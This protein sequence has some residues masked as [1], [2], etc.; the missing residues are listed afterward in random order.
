MATNNCINANSTTPLPIVD[1]GTQVIAVTTAPTATAFAGWDA[2]K[3]LSANSH[4]PGFLSTASSASP[5]TLVVGSAQLQFITGSTAQTIVMPVANTLVAGMNWTI[6]N[7]STATVTVNS[8][9]SNLIVSIPTLAYSTITCILNSGT[10]AASWMA[11]F[12]YNQNLDLTSAVQFNS[13]Q[14]NAANALLDANGA[15]LAS[16][17]SNASAVNYLNFKNGSTTNGPGVFAAG[18]DTNIILQL[19]GQGTGG[20]EVQAQQQGGNAAT[21]YVGQLNSSV[22]SNGSAVSISTVTATDLTSLVSLPSGDWDLYGNINFNFTGVTAYARAWISLAS[23]TEPDRSLVATISSTGLAAAGAG[24]VTPFYRLT[25]SVA[26]TVYLT[27]QCSFSTGICSMSGGI[28][29]RLR[30]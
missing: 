23:V 26:T 2:N 1:G 17:T 22:V 3:N 24:I 9:G 11:D 13:V 14:F 25:S 27:G 6:V 4:I 7:L 28:Y 19:A 21:G 15:V 10:S 5:I 8:S 16:I 30:R 20:V 29:A 12:T 18:S